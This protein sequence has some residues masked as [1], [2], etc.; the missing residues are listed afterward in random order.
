MSDTVGHPLFGYKLS[1]RRML[2]VQARL[3]SRYLLKE[4]SSVPS[5]SPAVIRIILWKIIYI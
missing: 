2:L 5:L 4:I 1:I 3:L